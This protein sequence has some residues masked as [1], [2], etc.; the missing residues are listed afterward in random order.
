[1]DDS[2]F[3]GSPE[4][5]GSAG[6]SA[7]TPDNPVRQ[8]E[9]GSMTPFFLNTP[10]KS[11]KDASRPSHLGPAAKLKKSEADAAKDG[12]IGEKAGKEGEKEGDAT[13]AAKLAEKMG[14]ATPLGFVS[15]VTG[16]S[17][18]KAKGKGG[19]KK[20][21]ATIALFVSLLGG[22]IGF[23][24]LGQAMQPFAL[25]NNLIQNF[26]RS[27]FS[28]NN[29]ITTTLRSVLKNNDK[30]TPELKSSLRQVG[31]EIETDDAGNVKGYSYAGDDGTI[32]NISSVKE[33]DGIVDT[34]STFA[35]KVAKA[36]EISDTQS[37]YGEV[38][39]TA[40]ERI[41]WEKNRFSDYDTDDAD[42]KSSSDGRFEELAANERSM[43]TNDDVKYREIGDDDDEN[44][45]TISKDEYYKMDQDERVKYEP[46][47]DEDSV[48]EI[49][50]KV[51]YEGKIKDIAD[52]DENGNGG[53]NE[54]IYEQ[55]EKS[56]KASVFSTLV[57]TASMGACV[58][59]GVGT[60]VAAITIG[61]QIMSSV[62]L[63]SGFLEATQKCQAGEGTCRSMHDYQNRMNSG[64][65]WSATSI[66][67]VF[68]SESAKSLNS[69]DGN[70]E[71]MFKDKGIL[72]D[73]LAGGI[74][75]K[76]WKSCVY[77]RLAAE[78]TDL[79]GDIGSIAAAWTTGG[80]SLILRQVVK[81]VLVSTAITLG[82]KMAIRTV[83]DWAVNLLGID[84]V[85]DMAKSIGGDFTVL[86]SKKMLSSMGQSVGHSTA[87]TE[88]VK[89]FNAYA[90]KVIAL[91]AKYDRD[92]L[93]PFDASSQH[94]FIGSIINSL[95]QFSVLNS[96]SGSPLTRI[97]SSASSVVSSSVASL[98][99]QA[100]AS[101]YYDF[102]SE[103]GDCPISNGIGAAADANNCYPYYVADVDSFDISYEDSREELC[104]DE[105]LKC[106]NNNT[107]IAIKGAI[108]NDLKEFIVYSTQRDVHPGLADSKIASDFHVM[109]TK[110]E[111]VDDIIGKI[112]VVGSIIGGVN[113]SIDFKN[114]GKIFGSDYVIGGSN[115]EKGDNKKVFNNAEAYLE[116][117]TVYTQFGLTDHSVVAEFLDEY[118]AE[119]PIDNSY[120]GQ[121]A[122]FSGLTK[123]EV[124]NTLAY[125]DYIEAVAKYQP[126][127]YYSFGD[128]NDELIIV[129]GGKKHVDG[130]LKTEITYYDLRNV[131]LTA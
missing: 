62:N 27:S 61:K 131:S 81:S 123:D 54:K 44:V 80:V 74:E 79:I 8:S 82:V 95:T 3:D 28:M 37:M 52:F 98:L 63:A 68:G 9:R 127:E 21:A 90:D 40:A 94:T 112:P 69:G 99:P 88:K 117:D 77:G 130:I 55:A 71:N 24:F 128:S 106:E 116:L 65:F 114:Q 105:Y 34:D 57:K 23:S 92:N 36:S 83:V 17:K 70:L 97:M 1:M 93:S 118:Y 103:P 91:R 104:G 31:V 14:G 6:E 38:K 43:L 53:V 56:S 119:N 20:K 32:K 47:I 75:L 84:E 122:R 19:V 108:K 96:A 60:A 42:V 2:D 110:N 58:Y 11:D 25:A 89:E 111:T 124:V 72:G 76:S 51:D 87:T 78:A 115:W 64:E 13:G 5:G 46:I 4:L 22:G 67:S 15:K 113:A 107:D 30:A 12:K 120:E 39:T 66:Q 7:S 121:L 125:M 73:M 101:A 35:S 48:N 100:S 129:D 126:G 10:G 33:F 50:S 85:T 49:K 16:K 41:G 26:N 102:A 59:A 29:R 109:E 86:G 18:E 45:K